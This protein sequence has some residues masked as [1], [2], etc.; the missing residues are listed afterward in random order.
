MATEDLFRTT[1]VTQIDAYVKPNN[2]ASLRLFTGSGYA[3][4][5]A[6]MINGHQAVHFAFERAAGEDQ[7]G[8]MDLAGICSASK[9]E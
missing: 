4:E 1:A 5:R 3:L 2:A 9:T 7:Q 8:G 6:E